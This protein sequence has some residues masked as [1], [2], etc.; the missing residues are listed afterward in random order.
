M[1]KEHYNIKIQD[2]FIVKDC[3]ANPLLELFKDCPELVTKVGNNFYKKNISKEEKKK[4]REENKNTYK[5]LQ[6]QYKKIPAKER[7]GDLLLFHQYNLKDFYDLLM[8]YEK[9]K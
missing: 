4:L 3:C 5:I 9:Y 1:D 8:E 2:M 7:R 6:K